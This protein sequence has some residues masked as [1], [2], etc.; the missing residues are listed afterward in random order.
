MMCKCEDIGIKGSMRKASLKD[1]R[2]SSTLRPAISFADD[3]R[4]KDSSTALRRSDS[5]SD[6]WE[7]AQMVKIRKR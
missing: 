4:H 2:S 5:K 1:T 7:K 3:Q 6:A